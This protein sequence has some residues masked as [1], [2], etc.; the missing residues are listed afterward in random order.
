[1]VAI[2]GVRG[3]AAA[4]VS[5]SDE[6]APGETV[7]V[8]VFRRD[9]LLEVAVVL[10]PRPDDAVWLAPLPSVT[11]AQRRSFE[12]WAGAPLEPAS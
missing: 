10:A 11:D 1:V 2:D 4:L 12:R 8:S 5:R 9:Q 3:D 6:R 7:R